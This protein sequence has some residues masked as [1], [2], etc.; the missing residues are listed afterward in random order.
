MD[1][2]QALALQMDVVIVHQHMVQRLVI[3]LDAMSR[4]QILALLTDAEI[5]RLLMGQHPV[6]L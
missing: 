5:V 1:S 2:H 4:Q 6:L 3:P